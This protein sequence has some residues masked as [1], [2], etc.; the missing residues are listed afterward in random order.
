[1][2]FDCTYHKSLDALH[3]GCEQPRAYFVPFSDKA[4]ALTGR[5]GESDRFVSLCGEWSFTF[6]PGYD[7]ADDF[8][9]EPFPLPNS[10]TIAVPMS[11]QS[12]LGRGYDTP[13]YTN[14]DYPFPIDPPHVPNENPCGLYQKR[15]FV[16]ETMLNGK[17][18]YINFEG[19][20]SCFY[21]FVNN[22]FVAYSQVSHM[23]SEIDLTP[24]VH[25][26]YN[27][28]SVLVFK[29]CDGSYLEDQDK[30]RFS[31]IFREVYLLVRDK[32]HVRD[33]EI[34]AYLSEG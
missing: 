16:S 29:W 10:E 1:M 19:V 32:V 15:V 26:G 4:V 3:V 13:N 33:I 22:T 8:L 20:D 21:L 18:L 24:Y 25:V 31:G 9:S 14:V 30:F 12:A 5:R 7:K 27:D 28:F 6:Y 34:K 2:K 23:T 17:S 11:W